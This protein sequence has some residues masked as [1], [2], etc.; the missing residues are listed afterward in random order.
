[1]NCEPGFAG[2]WR[3]TPRKKR[4]KASSAAPRSPKSLMNVR[5]QQ[6]WYIGSRRARTFSNCALL[7]MKKPVRAA[8]ASHTFH[9]AFHPD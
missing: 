2:G 9:R 1:M 7:V 3:A 5:W 4:Q 8:M 6:E